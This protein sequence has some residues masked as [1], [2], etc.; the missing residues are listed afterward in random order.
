MISESSPTESS[1]PKSAQRRPRRVSS[2]SARKR[3]IQSVAGACICAYMH[4]SI[5]GEP[6]LSRKRACVRLGRSSGALS[7]MGERSREESVPSK[8]IVI[9]GGSGFVGRRLVRKLHAR[10]D[11]VTVLSRNPLASRAVLPEGVRIAGYTP[12]KEGPWFDEI[13]H[14]DAVVSLTGEQIVGVRWSD[15]KKA[16]FEASRIGANE[17]LVNAIERV[18]EKHRPKV[19]V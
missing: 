7:G 19:L 10:K 8:R 12:T 18:P 2:P 1:S 16:E 11:L 9:A 5:F 4:R 15:A 13:A 3:E 14:T 6:R 17:M